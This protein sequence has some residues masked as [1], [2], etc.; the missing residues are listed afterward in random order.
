MDALDVIGDG[1][2]NPMFNLGNGKWLLR[3]TIN[4]MIEETGYLN[5]PETVD[6]EEPST[7]PLDLR[8][9]QFTVESEGIQSVL[10][11]RG[12]NYGDFSDN[13]QYAQHIKD[14]MRST[15][16]WESGEIPYYIQE[17]LDL[18]ASKISRML[19]GNPLYVDNWIDIQ[20]YAKLV[21]DR[22]NQETK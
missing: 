12:E 18:I 22:I 6:E 11:A 16:S 14:V 3:S 13:A 1:G 4:E 17:A 19:S 2:L 21:E 7:V 5:V 9:W 15:V 10:T 8:D 20:G